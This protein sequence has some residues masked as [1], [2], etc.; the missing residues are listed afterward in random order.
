MT[1]AELHGVLQGKGLVRSDDAMRAEAAVGV[2]RTIAYD[3]RS[4]G[5]RRR[6]R[7]AEG[8]ARR[9]NHVR[10]PGDRSRRRRRRLRAAGAGGRTGCLDR[11]RRCAAGARRSRGGVLPPS[12]RRH[13]GRRHHRHERQD[14]DGAICVASI[15]DA[16]DLRCGLLG[17]VGYRIGDPSCGRRPDTTPE[18]PD[19]Q[20]LLREM[21]DAAA[22]HARWRCRRTRC[23]CAASTA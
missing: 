16:A 23:R 14:D 5:A 15:F 10:A 19:V 17:T 7:R 18:A 8:A 22:A 2:V 3:S 11:G 9:R 12:E 13:A 4:G 1:W 6:V 20:S 21:V